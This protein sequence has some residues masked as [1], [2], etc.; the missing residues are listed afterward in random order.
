MKLK[1]FSNTF[2]LREK[3]L[4]VYF[5]II[6]TKFLITPVNIRLSIRIIM[7][8]DLFKQFKNLLISV[9]ESNKLVFT[10]AHK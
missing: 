9:K 2:L 8:L 5:L 6:L 4:Q 7:F 1:C 3:L 10:T